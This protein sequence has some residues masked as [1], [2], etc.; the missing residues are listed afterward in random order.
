MI[1]RVVTAC[2]RMLAPAT[3]IALAP[4]ACSGLKTSEPA[5]PGDA[6]AEAAS[7]GGVEADGA[8]SAFAIVHERADAGSLNAIWGAGPSEVHAVGDDGMIFDWDGTRWNEVVGVTG[9]KLGG[10]WGRGPNDAYAVGTLA[11]GARGIV[12]HYDGR[13]WTQQIELPTGLVSVWGIDDTIYAG[14]LDGVLYKKTS[15]RDWYRLIALEP[16][17]EIPKTQFSPILYSISGNAPDKV[18]VAG[19][20]D[21]VY[22]FR[23]SSQW[24]PFYDP[25]DRTRAYKSVW[26][27]RSAST[28]L[29]VGANYFGVWLFTDAPEILS[30]HEEKDSLDKKDKAIWGIWGTAS[31]H[32]MFVGD[33]GRIMTYDGGP[34]GLVSHP[35]PTQKSLFGVWGSSASDVWIV[36]EGATILRGKMPGT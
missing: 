30:L 29:Y 14:G 4:F 22:F 21:T 1:V 6:G 19:D 15:A 11:A 8:V 7:E 27:A 12:M 5:L 10:V 28:N 36:G 16:N 32:V 13:G 33:E 26:G 20:I 18:L 31:D 3:A 2:A 17:P 34:N 24:V 9:A 25:V 23:G 35:S